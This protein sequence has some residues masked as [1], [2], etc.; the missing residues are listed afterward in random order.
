M[1][2]ISLFVLVLLFIGCGSEPKKRYPQVA[3]EDAV[4]QYKKIQ[5]HIG[6]ERWEV[7]ANNLKQFMATHPQSDV[8]D[9]AAMSLGQLLESQQRY[10]EAYNAYS[11]VL[12]SGHISPVETDA[13]IACTRVLVV[14]GRP[15]EGLGLSTKALKKN[16]KPGQLMETHELRFEIFQQL[17]QRIAALGEA[18]WLSQNAVTAEKRELYQNKVVEWVDTTNDPDQLQSI[19]RYSDFRPLHATV[20]FKLGRTA[21]EK[22]DFSLARSWL[23][24]CISEARSQ[25]LN[26][27][28]I[29]RAQG[30]L[31]QIDIRRRV[32]A[33]TIGMVVP[34]TGKYSAIGY[35]ALKGVQLALGTFFPA[36]SPLKLAV[37]DSEGNSDL[38]RRGVERLVNEDNV[39]A[40]IGGL[41]SKTAAQEASKAQELGVP[42]IGLSQSQG[43][44][45]VGDYVF[46]NSLTS[47]IQMGALVETAIMKQKMRTFAILYP[48]DTY[49]NEFAHAFYDEV[50]SRGGE[51]RAVQSYDPKE[52]DFKEAIR[53]L[54]GTAYVD[55]RAEEYRVKLKEWQAKNTRKNA[56]PP[57][58]LL[59]PVVDFEA[60]FVPDSVKALGQIAP[61][62]SYN[63]VKNVKLLGTNLWNSGDLIKRGQKSVEGALFVDTTM[64]Q[65]TNLLSSQF[66]NDFQTTFQETPG[67]FEMLAFDAAALVR[68]VLVNGES[69][70]VGVRDSLASLQNVQGA[71]GTLSINGNREVSRRLLALTVTNGQIAPL[72]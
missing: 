4:Q 48:N 6:K 19:L 30:Y 17:N 10:N 38:A 44:T 24:K 66:F 27:P 59:P 32:R 67:L 9:A 53:K 58:D 36:G 43:L 61:M 45:D 14:L 57:D 7:T 47:R 8:T 21:Y 52:T 11:K 25:D 70:R 39:V 54:V 23:E 34:L 46:R 72:P 56:T 13:L 33:D 71:V 69:S 29:A 68:K 12:Q 40:I 16:P 22:G 41:T 20:A 49:G 28:Y 15:D 60:L 37:V 55:D 18:G 65:D 35:K 26:S 63:D 5:S 1:Q 64:D 62:L 2:I 50:I 31:D 42:F 51:I 3:T